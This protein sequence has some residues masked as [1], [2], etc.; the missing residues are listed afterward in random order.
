MPVGLIDIA[1]TLLDYLGVPIPGS[2]QGFTLRPLLEHAPGDWQR[3]P[4]FMQTWQNLPRSIEREVEFI[5]VT[6]GHHKLIWNLKLNAYS[7]Y[8]LDAD[9]GE[10]RSLIE[11]S[12]PPPGTWEKFRELGGYLLGWWD[13]QP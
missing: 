9:P 10:R 1:P 12:P 4:V 7:L 8:D 2:M 3:P 6:D 13:L 11:E 5:G